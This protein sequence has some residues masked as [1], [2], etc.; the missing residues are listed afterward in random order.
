[1]N[2]KENEEFDLV[3]TEKS[4]SK[5]SHTLEVL[6]N[7]ELGE[8]PL[9]GILEKAVSLPGVKIKRTTFLMETYQLSGTVIESE[10]VFSQ[11]SLEQ[12][13]KEAST[14]IARN[15]TASSSVAF[16]L[17]LP[18]GIAMMASVPADV[19]QN[20]AFSLRLAQQLAYVYGFEE[21]FENDEMSEK[22]QNTLIAFLG[23]MFVVTGS[24]TVLRAI[25]PNV[26]KYAAKQAL[27]RPLTRTVWYPMLKK[28]SNIVASKTITKTSVSGFASKAIPVV[29]GVASAGI[30]VATMIPMA[31]RLKNELRKY[32]LPE[33]TMEL[34]EKE[35]M[36]FG[37]K[38]SELVSDVAVN[39][40]NVVNKTKGIGAG[41]SKFAKEVGDKTKAKIEGQKK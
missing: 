12:M 9:I 1:M 19:M 29:G 39:A 3:E 15:V 4:D 6:G 11:I 36:E 10:D 26:G 40:V 22:T 20:F 34:E 18:G 14:I 7:Y 41:L 13:D 23:I 2:K 16:V 35:T 33:E 32:Y 8:N 5:M 31:N 24:G 27:R 37:E 28:I 25:A 38:A 21:L 17:G 30:N